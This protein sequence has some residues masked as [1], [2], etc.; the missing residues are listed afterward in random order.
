MRRIKPLGRT[1]QTVAG[2]RKLAAE[3]SALRG[4]FP[5]GGIVDDVGPDTAQGF[6]LRVPDTTAD[7]TVARRE[8]EIEQGRIK[9]SRR[10]TATRVRPGRGARGTVKKRHP[11]V[12]LVRRLVL[13]EA[14]IAMNTE[15][16]APH[17][18]RAGHK[19]RT[20]GRQWPHHVGDET[21]AGFPHIPLVGLPV[22]LEP[23]L[24]VVTRQLPE[25]SQR[26][27]REVRGGGGH[28]SQLRGRIA[29]ANRPAR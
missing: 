19:R 17:L 10:G 14:R 5:T 1:G 4:L 21:Q 7:E 29:S 8:V 25:E 18:L 22:G 15:Q 24:V 28:G 12:G 16:R 26:I 23:G 20:D 3:G 11:G 27:G 6:S 9:P 13:A 2:Q